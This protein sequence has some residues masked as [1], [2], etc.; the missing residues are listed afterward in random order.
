[1]KYP[2]DPRRLLEIIDK[3]ENRILDLES[4]LP[5][6]HP[7]EDNRINYRLSGKLLKLFNLLKYDK[8]V[9]LDTLCGYVGTDNRETV[10]MNLCHLRKKLIK[11]GIGITNYR[12]LGYCLIKISPEKVPFSM[13]SQL[14][15]LFSLL[16]Y[17][18]YST[19]EELIVSYRAK[20]KRAIYN[21]IHSLRMLLQNQGITIDHIQDKGYILRKMIKS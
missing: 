16:S 1:M 9:E 14:Q 18:K 19:I 15:E 20:N 17:S 13:S 10:R 8:A 6:Y 4:Q 3:L 21:K 12:G 5:V 2:T 7:I 11:H